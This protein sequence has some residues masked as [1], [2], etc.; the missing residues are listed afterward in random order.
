MH[1]S[2]FSAF[3]KVVQYASIHTH[4][5]SMHKFCFSLHGSM[6]DSMSRC[7]R[8]LCFWFSKTPLLASI[9]IALCRLIQLVFTQKSSFL[10]CY[11]SPSHPIITKPHIIIKQNLFMQFYILLITETCFLII[12]ESYYTNS[13]FIPIPIKVLRQIITL[14]HIQ[15]FQFEIPNGLNYS[16]DSQNL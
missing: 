3:S 4:L 9:H 15:L 5:V 11:E 7:M 10:H 13:P 2:N 16:I 1:S 14:G 8:F 12:Q 6:H